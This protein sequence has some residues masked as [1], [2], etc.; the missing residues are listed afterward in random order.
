VPNEG[1]VRKFQNKISKAELFKPVTTESESKKV[2][3]SAL[4]TV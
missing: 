1:H 3:N 2:R 4:L